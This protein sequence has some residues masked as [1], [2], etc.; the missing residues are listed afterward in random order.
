MPESS[1][2]S[3]HNIPFGVVSVGDGPKFP[4]TVIGETVINL[5]EVESRGMF[6]GAIMK[7]VGRVIFK[8]NLNEFLHLTRAHWREV[9]GTL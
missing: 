3:I 5:S 1:D 4:A 9:R 7:Y 8:D 2:F 6:D